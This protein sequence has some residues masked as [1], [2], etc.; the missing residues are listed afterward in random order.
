MKNHG[1]K[2]HEKVIHAFYMPR[3]RDAYCLP[4][5]FLFRSVASL[6]SHIFRAPRLRVIRHHLS[7]LISSQPLTLIKPT[8]IFS[9]VKTVQTY[10]SLL[11][12]TKSVH[13]LARYRAH[14]SELEAGRNRPSGVTYV[15][16]YVT[17]YIYRYV[18]LFFSFQFIFSNYNIV[19][20]LYVL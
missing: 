14:S 13:G 11:G 18:V 17:P 6:I 19:Y 20:S 5:P 7:Y 15:H 9:T 10:V 3:E 8:R 16:S 1:D 2:N 12:V 4:P